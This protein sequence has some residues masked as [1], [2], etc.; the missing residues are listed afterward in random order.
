MPSA[1]QRSLHGASVLLTVHFVWFG[2]VILTAPSAGEALALFGQL[3]G[4][5]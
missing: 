3:I 4:R 5:S 2:F 1:W